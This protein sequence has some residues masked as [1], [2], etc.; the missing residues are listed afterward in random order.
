MKPKIYVLAFNQRE[1]AQWATEQELNLRDIVYVHSASVLP[2]HNRKG[3]DRIVE[4]PGFAKKRGTFAITDRLKS[5]TRRGKF[6]IEKPGQDADTSD[7]PVDT[8]FDPADFVEV[9]RPVAP[10][11]DKAEIIFHA[12][13]DPADTLRDLGMAAWVRPETEAANQGLPSGLTEITNDT[14]LPELTL[15]PDQLRAAGASEEE[16]E[17]LTPTLTEEQKDAVDK[18]NEQS[19]LE[20]KSAAPVRRARRN[21]QQIA[22]DNAFAA[23]EADPSYDNAKEL[24]EATSALR[25]RDPSDPRLT[26]GTE[27]LDF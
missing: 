6:E 4:L 11:D 21:N 23:H 15:T 1:A 24:S 3:D 9:E 19:K 5:L 26:E 27:D 20:P 12:N 8:S 14:G 7:E 16:V 25:L 18:A 10:E 22:Y 13:E 2:Y 17:L